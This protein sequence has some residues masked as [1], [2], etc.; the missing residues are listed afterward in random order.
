MSTAEQLASLTKAHTDAHQDLLDF[1]GS[2]DQ[3]VVGKER[4]MDSFM[5]NADKTMRNYAFMP[6]NAIRNSLFTDE[7]GSPSLNGWSSAGVKLEA[8]HPYY[9][10][11]DSLYLEQSKIDARL[12]A[13]TA[14]LDADLATPSMPLVA[15]ITGNYD[16]H[17][18]RTGRGGLRSGWGAL[19]RG[20]ILK[21]TANAESNPESRAH[22][23]VNWSGNV[24]DYAFRERAQIRCWIKVIKGTTS[25]SH[26]NPGY[27]G[28][29]LLNPITRDTCSEF[30]HGWMPLVLNTYE[31]KVTNIT[32]S[33]GMIGF[34]N[35]SDIEV[36]LAVPWIGFYAH[37]YVNDPTYLT[38]R[39]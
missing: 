8:I 27:Q 2:L 30:A 18:Q 21:M 31:T 6:R 25:V 37:D 9:M 32:R 33:Y 38:L 5:A 10:G 24:N 28:G 4:E 29:S 34:S 14:T 16:T 19:G 23:Y 26:S 22:R 11:F 20:H 13:G 15:N 7:A 1:S 39:G 35:Q 12:A 17:R 36:Y 3:R